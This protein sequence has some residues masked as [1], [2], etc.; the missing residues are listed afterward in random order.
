MREIKYIVLHC[1]AGPQTQTVESIQGYWKN[2][3]GW[4]DPGYHFLIN[5][6]GEAIQLLSIEKPSNGVKGFNANSIHISYIGGIDSKGKAIDNRTPAQI[7]KQIELLVKFKAMFPKAEIK[8]H[9]DFDGVKKECPSF[10]VNE[11]L[12][13]VGIK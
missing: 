9:R 2:S 1:T 7:Q 5:A 12:K 13:C 3:L 11:W 8:G 4:R 6:K 10:D